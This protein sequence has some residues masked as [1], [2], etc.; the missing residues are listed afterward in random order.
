MLVSA[1][2]PED[3]CLV[4]PRGISFIAEGACQHQ[5]LS[6]VVFPPGLLRIGIHAFGESA[7]RTAVFPETLQYIDGWAFAGSHIVS[8]A[9][10]PSVRAVGSGAFADCRY[11]VSAAFSGRN[12][13]ILG[14]NVFACCGSLVSAVLPDAAVSPSAGEKRST[15]SLS[16]E[17]V[18]S[19]CVSLAAV[20]SVSSFVPQQ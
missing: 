17:S 4:M 19:G 10:P 6:A 14:E 8:A 18:F 15:G 2:V 20:S 11:L 16:A 9:L 3:S 13:V 12:P 1:A 5:P 7:V